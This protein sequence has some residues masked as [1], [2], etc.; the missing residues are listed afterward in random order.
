MMTIIKPD[1]VTETSKIP[2]DHKQSEL[3]VANKPGNL[4]DYKQREPVVVSIK[5][6]NPA[7]ETA[8][9]KKTSPSDGATS[10]PQGSAPTTKIRVQ[11]QG[12]IKNFQEREQLTKQLKQ[13]EVSSQIK[14]QS[15][16]QYGI[17][18]CYCALS[19]NRSVR[20]QYI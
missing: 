7:A 11:H 10:K 9:I 15:L 16:L 19:V 6:V 2:K 20:D 1:P 12:M 5:P 8:T 18:Y 17:N 3:V 13:H 4:G 14:R